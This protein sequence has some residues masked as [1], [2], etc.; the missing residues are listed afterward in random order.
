MTTA[1]APEDAFAGVGASPGRGARVRRAPRWAHRAAHAITLL[2]LPS[3]LWRLGLAMGFHLGYTDSG[4]QAVRPPGFSGPFYLIMLSVLTEGAAL[5][6]LGL[7][8]RW[9]EVIPRRVPFI[10]GRNIPP[11]AVLIP[12]WLGVAVLAFLWTPLL[13]WWAMP[14][15]GMTPAGH[16]LVGF[17]YLPIAAWAPLLAALAV[18]YRRRRR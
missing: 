15:D 4:L 8:Q 14:H 9:G 5:L 2:A 1:T 3:A 11:I 13:A 12:A 7:V 6:A 18:S 10:G 16:T 17:L